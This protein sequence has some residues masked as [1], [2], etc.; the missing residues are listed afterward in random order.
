[1]QAEGGLLIVAG[2]AL[3]WGR[4][5]IANSHIQ[6]DRKTFAG[7]GWT[8]SVGYRHYLTAFSALMGVALI[9]IGTLRLFGV[10]A[11]SE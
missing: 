8:R 7:A 1:M 9:A 11:P 6:R 2:I 5:R 3:L 10:L 4:K